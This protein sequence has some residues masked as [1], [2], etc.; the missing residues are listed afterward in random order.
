MSNEMKIIALN[1]SIFGGHNH[2]RLTVHFSKSVHY[3]F[4]PVVSRMYLLS[5]EKYKIFSL[6][7]TLFISKKPRFREALLFIR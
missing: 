2:F 1:I 7:S 4:N 6:N 3:A 5:K